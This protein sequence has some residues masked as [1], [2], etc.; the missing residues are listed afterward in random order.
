LLIPVS[1]LAVWFGFVPLSFSY[2][3]YMLLI[4]AA[5]LMSS[6]LLKLGFYRH[7]ERGIR[8]K[9]NRHRVAGGVKPPLI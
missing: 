9:N 3:G 8:K 4:I 6:E 7:L 2:Y 5:Y 1:P